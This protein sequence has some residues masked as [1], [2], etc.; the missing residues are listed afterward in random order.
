MARRPDLAARNRASATHGF[1]RSPT[2]KTWD[3]MHQRCSNSKSADFHRYG[4]RGISVCH[5]WTSFE[6]FLEDMGPRPA[7][8]TLDRVDVNGAYEPTNCRWA[9]AKQQSNNR[10]SSVFIEHDGRRMTVAMWADEV[11]LERKTLEYR[12]RTGW[13]AA[14]ALTTPSLINRKSHGSQPCTAQ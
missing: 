8:C 4:A 11:G 2:Y 6:L 3:A 12:I 1:S 7:G 5:R 14:K 13:D 9:T 10:R